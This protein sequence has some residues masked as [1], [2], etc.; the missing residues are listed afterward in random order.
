M[1]V[2]EWVTDQV[3]DIRDFLYALKNFKNKYR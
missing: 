2:D 3:S 1:S